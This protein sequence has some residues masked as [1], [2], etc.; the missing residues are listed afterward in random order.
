MVYN[1]EQMLEKFG[2]KYAINL[3]DFSV[4]EVFGSVGNYEQ[5]FEDEVKA[6]EVLFSIIDSKYKEGIERLEFKRELYEKKIFAPGILNILGTISGKKTK[7]FEFLAEDIKEVNDVRLERIK[8]I[9]TKPIERLDKNI[10]YQV[11][12]PELKQGDYLYLSLHR[13]NGL[14]KGIYKIEIRKISRYER[15][16]RFEGNVLNDKHTPIIGFSDEDGLRNHLTH[17][18]FF[19]TEQEAK[20]YYNNQ[21]DKEIKELLNSKIN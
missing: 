6:K 13:S 3:A 7:V 12:Y 14:S 8:N 20:D 10:S 5:L 15:S 11:E 18:K 9:E 2:I 17:Y 16:F 1:Y 4:Y 21:I 19:L